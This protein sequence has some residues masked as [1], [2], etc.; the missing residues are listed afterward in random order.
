MKI[1]LHVCCANCTIYPV[2]ELREEGIETFGF[3]YNPNIHPYQEYK[4]RLRAVEEYSNKIKLNMTYH[5]EYVLEEFLQH[6]VFRENER[7]WYCYYTRLKRTAQLAK[8]EN[9]D[10]FTTTLL[11][12]KFQKHERVKEIGQELAGKYRIK[13]YYKD[14][15]EGWEDGIKISKKLGLYRQQ[16]CG[17]IYSEKERYLKKDA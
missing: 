14:F 1:L 16:Y 15:R 13:F 3:F 8:T 7:C 9:F 4:R 11:Y 6:I 17:C 5:D 10:F 2:Q 12:S